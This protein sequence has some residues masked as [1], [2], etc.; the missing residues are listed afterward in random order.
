MPIETYNS[1]IKICCN[2]ILIHFAKQL[3]TSFSI[4]SKTFFLTG[5]GRKS[6]IPIFFPS[7]KFSIV[8]VSRTHN[9]TGLYLDYFFNFQDLLWI[10]IYFFIL[11]PSTSLLSEIYPFQA[12]Q[13]LS[14]L[15]WTLAVFWIHFQF[16]S[17]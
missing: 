10:Y 17:I 12:S 6:T 4:L 11:E 7:L 9:C 14:I 16:H 3:D 15:T 5:F 1:M 8:F 2:I 13:Y